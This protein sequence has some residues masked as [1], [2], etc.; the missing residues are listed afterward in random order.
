[1]YVTG[2]NRW[3]KLHE[4]PPPTT[5]AVRYLQPGGRL[6][7]D[8]P[9]GAGP[10][11][12]FYYDPADPTP[13]LGGRLLTADAGV[14]DNREL[15]AR[16]DVLTFTTPPL[17]EPME[18]IGTP[19]VELVHSRDNRYADVFVRLCEVDPRGRSRN[20][21]DTYLRLDPASPLQRQRLELRLDPCA[22]RVEP[23]HRLRL[24]VSGGAHPRFAR[25]EGIGVPA[26]ARGDLRPCVHTVHHA[27]GA[28]SRVVL[29]I[30]LR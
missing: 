11:T 27:P 18:I 14:R 21:S 4:W 7:A 2:A 25:N 15:E 1:V 23:G 17:A 5:A 20:F 12:P 26:G 10:S 22:H 16:P 30:A 9:A 6:S 13:S 3:Q 24:Q 28:A 8:E 19:V 29:P